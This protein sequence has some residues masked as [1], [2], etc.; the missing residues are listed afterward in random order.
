MAETPR[1]RQPIESILE[2]YRRF[3]EGPYPAQVHTHLAEQAHEFLVQYPTPADW[4]KAYQE[5]VQP[6]SDIRQD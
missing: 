5:G 3:C 6:L 4:A 1:P 2:E